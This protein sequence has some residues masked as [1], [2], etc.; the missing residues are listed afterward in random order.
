MASMDEKTRSHEEYR[1]RV[2]TAH[3]ETMAAIQASREAA[4]LNAGVFADAVKQANIDI[5]GGDGEFFQRFMQA[6][7]VGKS[8]DG[9]INKSD[10]LKTTFT[11]HLEGKANL[12]ED[13]KQVAA[14]LGS[15]D[16]QNLSVAAFLNKLMAHG[17]GEDKSK[18]RALLEQL[19]Q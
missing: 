1:L 3:N 4:E 17:S 13:V 16:L 8:I 19:S 2:D 14:N 5:V 18:V 6:L 7:A 9:A 15:D 10:L 12:L 11:D